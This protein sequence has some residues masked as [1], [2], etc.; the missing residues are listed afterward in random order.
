MP[1]S[2]PV[3]RRV[4]TADIVTRAALLFLPGRVIHAVRHPIRKGTD[5]AA[6]SLPYLPPC[7][8]LEGTYRRSVLSSHWMLSPGS[9]L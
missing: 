9:H 8:A 1:R 3:A 7:P 4:L 6:L 2:A 5:S